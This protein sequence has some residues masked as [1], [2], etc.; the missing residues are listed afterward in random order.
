MDRAGERDDLRWM[1]RAIR[2]ASGPGLAVSPNPR[3]GAVLAAGSELLAEG[4]HMRFGGRHAERWALDRWQRGGR[5]LPRGATLYISLEPCTHVGKTPPCV[6]AIL[7]AGVSS[8]AVALVDPDPRVRGRGIRALRRAGVHVSV[9]LMAGEAEMLNRPYL[10]LRREGRAR[11][12]LKIAA[13]LDGRVADASG[14]SR[15]ITGTDSRRHV[16][17]LRSACDAVVVGSGTV[18]A[19]DPRLTVRLVD[20]GRR[21]WPPGRI[22][23]SGGLGFDPDCR[24]AVAWRRETAGVRGLTGRAVGNWVERNDGRGW[25]RRPRLVVAAS[26]P[27]RRRAAAFASRGWEVWDL[28]S[29]SRGV[30]LNAL[31]RKAADEGLPDLLIEPGPRLAGSFLSEGPVDEILLFLAPTMLGAS[32]R[33]WMEHVASRRL[34]DALRLTWE[35]TPRRLG[36]DLLVELAG[37]GGGAIVPPRRGA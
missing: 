17:R 29:G 1:R 19:D 6:D 20:T 31:A 26:S 27:P 34:P 21:S 7:S 10:V 2:I 24:V 8:V 35:G 30:D 37:P 36:G 9:G 12:R 22:V 11:V 23:I 13:T 25:I 15:W 33:G 16:A 5:R 4:R 18:R 32:G 28:P 3:V 14:A